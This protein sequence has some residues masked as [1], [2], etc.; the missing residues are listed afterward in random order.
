MKKNTY[1]LLILLLGVQ[2]ISFAQYDAKAKEILDAMSN[3]YKNIS[4]YKAKFST[5]LVNRE[6]G[7]NET[8]SGEIT[9][10]GDKY[11]LDT[12]DQTVINNGTT[13]WTYL[14]DVNEVNID[15]YDPDE[16][17][18]TPS[19]IFDE[20]KKGYKYIWLETTTQDGVTCDVLDL[21]PNDTKNNQFFKIKMVI[22]SRDKT[23]KKWT[24]FEKSG[25]Q[26]IYTISDFKGNISVSDA[27]FK[28]DASKY[29]NVEVVDL[30]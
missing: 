5:S 13:V 12:E 15:V 6:D 10:K 7:V 11:I 16:D 2:M 1:L 9:I 22:A 28:F 25:N 8:F 4:A 30:R 18:I 26:H 23:L 21:V 27:A 24:M 29:P 3:K 17:E 19:N 20:Y 14:P